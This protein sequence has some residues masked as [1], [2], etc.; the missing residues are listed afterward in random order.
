M[1]NRLSKKTYSTKSSFLPAFLLISVAVIGIAFFS[2]YWYQQAQVASYFSQIDKI[3]SEANSKISRLDY[4]FKQFKLDPRVAKEVLPYF[5]K[6]QRALDK[7]VSKLRHIKP[8]AKTK[9]HHKT[10]LLLYGKSSKL[11]NDL[12]SVASYIK[13]RNKLLV[14]LFEEVQRFSKAIKEAKTDEDAME[15]AKALKQSAES[16]SEELHNLSAPVK[17]YSSNQL[18]QNLDDLA[19]NLAKLEDAI[20]KK[21]LNML[22]ES[23]NGLKSL[24]SKDWSETLL[25]VD[26][27]G[28]SAYKKRLE[29]LQHLK[30][31]V[32]KSR[33]DI[34]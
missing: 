25:E 9:T 8:P 28:V 32:M 33:A 3:Q 34:Q 24:F 20:Q 10:L 2:Y 26:T 7:T 19:A 6:A 17:I 16:T 11:C 1:K 29:E 15:A 14:H 22:Q 23:A 18:E 5:K 31:E 30:V 27:K 21:D 4:I 12:A 13:A